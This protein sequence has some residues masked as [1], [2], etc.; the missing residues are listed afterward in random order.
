MLTGVLQTG[1]TYISPCGQHMNEIPTAILMFS[2]SGNADRQV[3]NC[4]MP[5]DVDNQRW[6]PLTGSRNDIA[7]ISASTQDSNY[8]IYTQIFGVGLHD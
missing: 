6:R 5:G 7:Y 3:A 8:N 2:G 1:S 4:P